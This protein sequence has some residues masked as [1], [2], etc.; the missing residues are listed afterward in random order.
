MSRIEIE[1]EIY[2]YKQCISESPS[3]LR[4]PTTECI[5]PIINVLYRTFDH[6]QICV[7]HLP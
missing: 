1:K 2:M 4:K 5:W 3:K 6:A 7:K